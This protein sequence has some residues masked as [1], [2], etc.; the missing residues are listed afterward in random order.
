QGLRLV[1][2]RPAWQATLDV[3]LP[4]GC[5]DCLLVLEKRVVAL[6]KDRTLQAFDTQ[7]GQPVWSTRLDDLPRRLPVVGR[8]LVVVQ[9]SEGQSNSQILLIDAAD[10]KVARQIA[11][12][13]TRGEPND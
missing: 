5:D 12:T 3:E 9:N 2:G 6:R 11:P 4:S 1:D 13:C 10:G 7:T 8:R